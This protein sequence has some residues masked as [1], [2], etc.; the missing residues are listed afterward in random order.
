M[1]TEP[2]RDTARD[3]A[4][5][6]ALHTGPA[7]RLFTPALA[8]SSTKV[9][10]CSRVLHPYSGGSS[11]PRRRHGRYEQVPIW[12]ATSGSRRSSPRAVGA[13]RTTLWL[14]P[15]WRLHSMRASRRVRI[16]SEAI[17]ERV[18]A[19]YLRPGVANLA[20]GTAHWS[21][22]TLAMLQAGAL[23]GSSGG[24]AGAAGAAAAAAGAKDLPP[25]QRGETRRR[26]AAASGLC[27][28]GARGAS[29]DGAA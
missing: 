25:R 21:P 3:S 14:P 11:S 24:A 26:R 20:P 7:A 15:K 27:S 23:R 8:Y 13:E 17:V 19:S 10:H 18:L 5:G 2:A 22:P 29:G 28:P 16:A 1:R 12:R 9:V 4:C 6:T